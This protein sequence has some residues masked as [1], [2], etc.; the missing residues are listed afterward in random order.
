[1]FLVSFLGVRPLAASHAAASRGAAKAGL[2]PMEIRQSV[3]PCV[4]AYPFV[5]RL[6]TNDASALMSNTMISSTTAV[7]Y[8]ASI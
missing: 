2:A 5:M 8:V 6:A 4:P 3:S 1:M 7:A